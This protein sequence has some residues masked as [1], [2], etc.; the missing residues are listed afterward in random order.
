MAGRR[1][2]SPAEKVLPV[3]YGA[4]PFLP[5]TFVLRSALHTNGA[6][7]HRGKATLVANANLDA[8]FCHAGRGGDG[9]RVRTHDLRHAHASWLLAG[10]TD[11]QTM[12]ERLGHASIITTEKHL[13]SLAETGETAL[14][15]LASIRPRHR[16][17]QRP[18]SAS[19]KAEGPVPSGRPQGH[20]AS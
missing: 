6:S 11:I 18:T 5:A 12:T 1:A 3:I 8:R 7:A 15:A 10:G 17:D 9:I 14:V 13:H 16:A 19:S 20:P 2:P 4:A